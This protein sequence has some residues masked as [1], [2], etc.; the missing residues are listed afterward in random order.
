MTFLLR[1]YTLPDKAVVYESQVCHVGAVGDLLG[2]TTVVLVA[3]AAAFKVG[4]LAAW[5]PVVTGIGTPVAVYVAAARNDTLI[6]EYLRT[7]QRLS[8]RFNL[9]SAVF[10]FLFACLAAFGRERVAGCRAAS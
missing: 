9:L 5:L 7:A 1:R 8:L 3:V 6:I 10:G 2:V 4:G